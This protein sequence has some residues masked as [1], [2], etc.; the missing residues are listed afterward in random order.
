MQHSRGHPDAYNPLSQIE[1]DVTGHVS[2]PTVAAVPAT[3]PAPAPAPAHKHGKQ[4]RPS[5][6]H[7]AP[8]SSHPAH[9]DESSD[10][11][12]S[13]YDAPTHTDHDKEKKRTLSGLAA[14][15]I[16]VGAAVVCAVLSTLGVAL[17]AHRLRQRG[18]LLR[19]GGT[20]LVIVM[21]VGRA[22]GASA[23]CMNDPLQ[24]IC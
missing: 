5:P 8:P 17:Y 14:L 9:K 3:A 13:D 24:V 7:P 1:I 16:S 15:G 11:E 20:W 21:I 23:S 18:M 22:S 4:L 19:E 6:P 2:P 12:T 10:E